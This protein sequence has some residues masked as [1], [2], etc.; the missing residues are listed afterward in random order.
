[1]TSFYELYQGHKK[2]LPGEQQ[3]AVE[4]EFPAVVAG[5]PLLWCSPGSPPPSKGKRLVIG[6]GTYS[7]EDMKL[8]DLVRARAAQSS[9]PRVEVFSTLACKS[10]EDFDKYVPG[11]GRVYQ[12]PVAGLWVDGVLQE[13][14]TGAKARALIARACGFDLPA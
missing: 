6:A 3:A 12:T 13:A 5:S 2:L 11:I 1:M 4:R 14:A 7:A 8:L 10:H 9:E